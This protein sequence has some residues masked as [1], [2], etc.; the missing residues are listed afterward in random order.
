[1]AVDSG[2]DVSQNGPDNDPVDTSHTVQYQVPRFYAR[3]T[4]RQSRDEV[5]VRST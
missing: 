4:A 3:T 1:M 2:S 5:P